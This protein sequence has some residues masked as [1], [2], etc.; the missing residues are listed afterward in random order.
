MSE[1]PK[2]EG[3]LGARPLSREVMHELMS[4]IRARAEAAAMEGAAKRDAG[5]AEDKKKEA[6]RLALLRQQAADLLAAEK[7]KNT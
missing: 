5:I 7:G 3:E 2:P 1:K 6:D 4:R